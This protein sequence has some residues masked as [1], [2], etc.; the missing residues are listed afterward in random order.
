[1]PT[2]F[3]LFSS[4]LNHVGAVDTFLYL[5]KFFFLE[6][7][8]VLGHGNRLLRPIGA[9]LHMQAM[10]GTVPSQKRFEGYSNTPNS[11]S[12]CGL[13]AAPRVWPKGREK[14]LLDRVTGSF[15]HLR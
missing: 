10:L 11:F 14:P 6:V 1:M 7:T 8:L 9:Y 3:R 4:D 2:S 5:A 12:V 13:L 15:G